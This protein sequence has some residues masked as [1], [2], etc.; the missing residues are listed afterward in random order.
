MA[1]KNPRKNRESAP[2]GGVSRRSFLTT[3][4]VGTVGL[5]VAGS[6]PAAEAP[7]AGVLEATEAARVS[8]KING[9]VHRLLV[10]PRWSLLFVLRTHKPL[11]GGGQ[12]QHH[13]LSGTWSVGKAVARRVS[14][15]L[16][17]SGHHIGAA[18]HVAEDI[19][20]PEN[21]RTMNDR[22]AGVT[23]L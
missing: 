17:V 3:A 21:S 14:L 18:F 20:P 19:H 9:R 23:V 5:A 12:L 1:E 10:E 15:A 7:P 22:K 6:A 13:D 16:L 8:L 4:G 2:S 11:F